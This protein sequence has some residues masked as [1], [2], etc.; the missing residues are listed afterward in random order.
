MVSFPPWQGIIPLNAAKMAGI[1]CDILVKD[2]LDIKVV[3][4]RLDA[5]ELAAACEESMEVVENRA[6]A[7]LAGCTAGAVSWQNYSL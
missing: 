6:T 7:L 3:F 2:L 4:G 1:F 5:D